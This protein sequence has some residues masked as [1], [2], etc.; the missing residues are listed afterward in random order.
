MNARGTPAHKLYDLWETVLTHIGRA[1]L[2]QQR[3]GDHDPIRGWTRDD[4]AWTHWGQT[5]HHRIGIRTF[6]WRGRPVFYFGSWTGMFTLTW[7]GTFQV[8]AN[9]WGWKQRDALAE[10][11]FLKYAA[12]A[13]RYQWFV[14]DSGRVI[15]RPDSKD[16]W[17]FKPH[18]LPEH[19]LRS[20]KRVEHKYQ[21]YNQPPTVYY[22]D[23]KTPLHLAL[24]DVGGEWQICAAPTQDPWDERPTRAGARA[25][26]LAQR[27]MD[28]EARLRDWRYRRDEAR[29]YD[30]GQTPK[31]SAPAASLKQGNRAIGHEKSIRLL[32]ALLSDDTP[33]RMRPMPRGPK[34]AHNGKH[35][36]AA[37]TGA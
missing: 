20:V 35:D 8:S 16:A 26:Q 34:E 7:D 14:G 17:R 23:E 25:S 32:A 22:R 36:L 28:A 2:I 3:A 37:A 6:D 4:K 9:L 29:Y 31:A 33:A 15:S 5:P 30:L 13:S 10:A 27:Q 19:A 24:H 1:P 18:Y 11:T 21:G 12:V